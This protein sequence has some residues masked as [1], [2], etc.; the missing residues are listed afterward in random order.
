MIFT[1]HDLI[2][3]ELIDMSAD[4]FRR[5]NEAVRMNICES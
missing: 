4:N 3:Q 2:K 1:V 5:L